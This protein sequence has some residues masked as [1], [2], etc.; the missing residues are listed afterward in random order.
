MLGHR[1]WR[2]PNIKATQGQGCL[3][4]QD[5]STVKRG[6]CQQNLILMYFVFLTAPVVGVL[7]TAILPAIRGMVTLIVASDELGMCIYY[8][9]YLII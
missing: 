7:A 4:D 6:L 8:T 5:W 1:L 2:W 3:F 9:L